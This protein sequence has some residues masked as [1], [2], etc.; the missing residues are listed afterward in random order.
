MLCA[1][2]LEGTEQVLRTWYTHKH[3]PVAPST[4]LNLNAGHLTHVSSRLECRTNVRWNSSPHQTHRYHLHETFGCITMVC[5]CVLPSP[6]T[7]LEH[8][9]KKRVK[10]PLCFEHQH[11]S[12]RW[13]NSE[14]NHLSVSDLAG[15]HRVERPGA[16]PRH[17]ALVTTI[18]H[19]KQTDCIRLHPYIYPSFHNQS[20]HTFL[21][22]T[23]LCT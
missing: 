14:Q 8:C 16:S 6:P 12:L 5:V 19:E 2:S 13:L 3:L 17:A 18:T 4:S 1:C 15:E 22:S 21:L 20:S 10:Q 9:I 7:K 23:Q 11:G